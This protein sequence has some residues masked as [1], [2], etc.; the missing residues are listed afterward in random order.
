[1]RA[2]LLDFDLPLHTPEFQRAGKRKYG[3]NV[4]VNFTTRF[5]A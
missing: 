2:S 1:M 3:E 4:P 5:G